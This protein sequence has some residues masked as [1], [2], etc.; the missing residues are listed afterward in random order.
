MSGVSCR[1]ASLTETI[2]KRWL[3]CLDSKRQRINQRVCYITTRSHVLPPYLLLHKQANRKTCSR[4]HFFFVT[5]P[6]SCKE[7]IPQKERCILPLNCMSFCV[8][9]NYKS[10]KAKCPRFL[11]CVHK[12]NLAVKLLFQTSTTPFHERAAH[13]MGPWDDAKSLCVVSGLLVWVEGQASPFPLCSQAVRICSRDAGLGFDG[14]PGDTA[15]QPRPLPDF[16]ISG[17]KWTSPKST[18]CSCIFLFLSGRW[19]VQICFCCRM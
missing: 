8:T 2:F 16:V 5:L 18:G 15:Q 19:E 4:T 3:P 7:R 10:Y 12:I 13:W 14:L 6:R 1:G 11:L 9:Y 17:N